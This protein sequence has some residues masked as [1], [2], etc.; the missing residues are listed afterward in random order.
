MQNQTIEEKSR[1]LGA[2]V[3]YY[4]TLK[5]LSQAAFAEELGISSQYLSRIE[6]GRQAPSFL[7]LLKI[8]DKLNVNTSDLVQD[9]L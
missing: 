3:K 4:R 1:L 9:R 6:S 8:A 5:G 2:K 7:T